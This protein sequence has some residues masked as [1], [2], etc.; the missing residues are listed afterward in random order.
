MEPLVLPPLL[1]FDAHL[2]QDM[3]MSTIYCGGL[4]LVPCGAL[5]C[6]K[7]HSRAV[8]RVF[9]SVKQVD[10]CAEQ[11]RGALSLSLLLCK[12]GMITGCED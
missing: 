2:S 3:F 4:C 10:G 12:M 11:L 7:E 8:P 6:E 9:I 5:Q 1:T